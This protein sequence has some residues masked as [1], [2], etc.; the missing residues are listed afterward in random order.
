MFPPVLLT[1]IG[2]F[3]DDVN[4]TDEEHEEDVRGSMDLG[5]PSAI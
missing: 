1:N 5:A 4:A 2:Y 3:L